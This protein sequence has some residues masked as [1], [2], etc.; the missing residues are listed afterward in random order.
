[1]KRIFTWFIVLLVLCYPFAIYFG[2][3]HFSP[4]YIAVG[5]AFIFLLRFIL[6]KSTA[7]SRSKISLILIT[8]AGIVISVAG[9]ISNNSLIIK[10]YPFVINL[11]MFGI[12]FNSILHPPTI[13]EKLAKIKT[14]NL[15]PEAI[16]YTRKVTITWCWF[17]VINGLIALWTTLFTSIKIWTFYNGFLSYIFIGIIFVTEYICRQRV[18]KKSS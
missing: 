17:F 14:P 13:I 10:L 12:F 3:S 7:S 16:K 1:M 15:P 11:L 5:L 9:I 8:A 6:F 2:L 18:K 4:R